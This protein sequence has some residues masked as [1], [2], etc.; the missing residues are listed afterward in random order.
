MA[1]GAI[2]SAILVNVASNV[3]ASKILGKDKQKPQIGSGTVPIPEAG[4]PLEITPVEGSQV[5]SFGDFEYDDPAKPAQKGEEEEILNALQEAGIRPEDLDQYGVVGMYL[6]GYLKRNLGGGMGIMDL[7]QEMPEI[8]MPEIDI[9]V[10]EAP[11]ATPFANIVGWFQSLDPETQKA[12]LA[13]AKK[14]GIA[15]L[16]RVVSG[17]EEQPGSLVS[18][19]TLPGNAAR[20]RAVQM[21]IQPIQ[22]SVR[23]AADGGVL[24]RPMFMPK[25]GAMH[26]RGG[27]KDDLI[28]VM[29]SNGEYMLSKAAVDQAGDGS[30][31]MGI[32]R[33]EAFNK[34]GNRRYG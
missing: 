13:G 10:P 2:L 34:A 30:H 27:P 21:N 14:V 18:T 31:P 15:G 32:A 3:L 29:A 17:K 4:S 20:R 12:L 16:T 22:G 7:M 11:E 28:P 5:Q 9:P 8:E 23:T 26:G 19:S 6:G 24:N 33:L 25:G 1:I